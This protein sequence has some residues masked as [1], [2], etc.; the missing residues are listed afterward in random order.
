MCVRGAIGQAF[1]L[2]E[3]LRASASDEDGGTCVPDI[4]RLHRRGVLLGH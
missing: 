4:Y 1:M 2:P 3:R